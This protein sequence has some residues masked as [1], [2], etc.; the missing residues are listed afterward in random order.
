MMGQM[1]IWDEE[2]KKLRHLGDM[3]FIHIEKSS[4]VMSGLVWRET[5]SW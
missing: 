2:V 4:R 1:I 3:S 5:Q